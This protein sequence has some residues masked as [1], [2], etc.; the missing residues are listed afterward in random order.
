MCNIFKYNTFDAGVFYTLSYDPELQRDGSGLVY[1]I[2]NP[3][4]D[5]IYYYKDDF[6]NA[7]EATKTLN[8]ENHFEIQIP[9]GYT[10]RIY[11]IESE[12]PEV[13]STYFFGYSDSASDSF[14]MLIKNES[15]EVYGEFAMSNENVTNLML[16]DTRGPM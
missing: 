5:K 11:V 7:V 9:E 16:R 12:L 8:S 2:C 15:G 14:G 1:G 4:I 10:V 13:Y 3:A 6:S